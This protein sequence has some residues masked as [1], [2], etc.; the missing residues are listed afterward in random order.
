MFQDG[1]SSLAPDI[2]YQFLSLLH[3]KLEKITWFA[4]PALTV[5]AG[6][7][8]GVFNVTDVGNTLVAERI[9]SASLHRFTLVA[10]ALIAIFAVGV[11]DTS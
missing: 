6:C 2:R 3:H 8:W 7:V 11:V 4:F 1:I 9:V 10:L 5:E